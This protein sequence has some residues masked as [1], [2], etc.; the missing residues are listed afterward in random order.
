MDGD[1]DR[2]LGQDAVE[3]ML[4]RVALMA[5]HHDLAHDIA[6]EFWRV[7]CSSHYNGFADEDVHA[8]VAAQAARTYLHLP[9]EEYA[10]FLLSYLNFDDLR[11]FQAVSAAFVESI[12]VRADD[13]YGV[14]D[15]IHYELT[16]SQRLS[17]YQ[18]AVEGVLDIKTI[19][20]AK[21]LGGIRFQLSRDGVLGRVNLRNLGSVALCAHHV[22]NQRFE[23]ATA[24]NLLTP[25]LGLEELLKDI[26]SSILQDRT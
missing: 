10:D 14:W 1:R 25:D 2:V 7:S 24:I 9:D 13:P 23:Q 4:A 8:L 6:S 19:L 17:C 16:P 3:P 12:I 21:S 11:T 22:L 15:H 18:I 20:K 26:E 5:G